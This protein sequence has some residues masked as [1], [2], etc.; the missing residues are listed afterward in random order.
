M[1]IQKFRIGV[2]ASFSAMDLIFDLIAA[3]PDLNRK[4]TTITLYTCTSRTQQIHHPN[5]KVPTIQAVTMID[6]AAIARKIR[7]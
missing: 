6:M 1:L 5:T 3:M 7:H 4:L 2:L